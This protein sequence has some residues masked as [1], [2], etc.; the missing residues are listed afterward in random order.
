M[1]I[2]DF[3]SGKKHADAAVQAAAGQAAEPAKQDTAAAA[4]P[5]QAAAP[6]SAEAGAYVVKE[7]DTLW[8]I[9][10][11]HYGAGNGGK[12]RDIFEANADVLKD[13]D[14]IHPGQ[15]LRIPGVAVGAA[16]GGASADWTPPQEVAA[17]KPAA[18]SEGWTPPAQISGK[19]DA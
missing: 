15:R 9:A 12:Y 13:P 3:L 2:L 8:K 14:R 10:E 11:A 18:P 4:A 1:G 17:A 19:K 7:G 5:P 6:A 16:P